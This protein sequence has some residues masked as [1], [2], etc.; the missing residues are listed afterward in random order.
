MG[1]GEVATRDWIRSELQ[2]A[3]KDLE[4]LRRQDGHPPFPAERTDR[5]AGR[6]AEDH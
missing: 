1:L 5:P 6:D 2:D 4:Q 3:I